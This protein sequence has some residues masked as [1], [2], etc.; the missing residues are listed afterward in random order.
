MEVDEEGNRLWSFSSHMAGDGEEGMENSERA[1][2]QRA[3]EIG[4]KAMQM[5]YDDA[6]SDYDETTINEFTAKGRLQ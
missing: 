5:A 1:K 6:A 4:A 2:L 3:M